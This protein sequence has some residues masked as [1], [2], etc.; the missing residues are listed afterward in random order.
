MNQQQQQQQQ[1]QQEAIVDLVRRQGY[2]SIEQ[3]IEHFTVTPQTIRRDLNALAEEGLI[4]RVHGGAGLDRVP[5]TLPTAPARPST[6]TPSS[7]LRDIFPTAPRC[8]SILAPAT[9]WWPRL[10][11]STAISS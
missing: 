10:C 6:S 5:S 4:R 8:S 9:R 1:Q 3:L 2:A 7:A 11:W